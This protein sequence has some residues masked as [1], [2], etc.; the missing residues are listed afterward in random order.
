MHHSFPTRRSSDLDGTRR[1]TPPAPVAVTGPESYLAAIRLGSGLAQVPRFH[2]QE[3]LQNGRLV[4]LLPDWT[5]PSAPV[6]LL[7]PRSRHLSPRV[8]A[9]IEW[10]TGEFAARSAQAPPG[11]ARRSA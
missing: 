6:S 4:Q 8:R 7:Y 5:V 11:A 3:D 1:I 10:A 2:I 9:F